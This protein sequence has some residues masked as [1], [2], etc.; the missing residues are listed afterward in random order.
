MTLTADTLAVASTPIRTCAGC[1]ARHPQGRLLRFT[2]RADGQVIPA[3]VTRDLSGRS[4]YLCPRRA[5]LEQAIK[6]RAFARAFGTERRRLSVLDVDA[7]ALWAATAEQLRAEIN[8]LART[9]IR[10]RPLRARPAFAG[11]P[12]GCSD[13][14][15]RLRSG[16]KPAPDP[17]SSAT[18]LRRR[19]LEQLLSELSSQPQAPGRSASMRGSTRPKDEPSRPQP[20]TPREKGAPSHG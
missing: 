11:S 1:R 8:L 15:L 5:C 18:H 19:G 4:T 9:S 16:S 12:T 2:R 17:E 14:D 3:N 6:R 20:H 13:V 10:T 7:D